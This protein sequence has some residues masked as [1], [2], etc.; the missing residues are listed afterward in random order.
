ML[1]MNNNLHG[2]LTNDAQIKPDTPVLNIP[3]ITLYTT[4]HLPKLFCLTTE[5]GDLSPTVMRA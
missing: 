5:S 4:F 1:V 2:S 3:D